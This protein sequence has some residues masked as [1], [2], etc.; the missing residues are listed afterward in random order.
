ANAPRAKTSA[1]AQKKRRAR[2]SSVFMT[3]SDC[4]AGKRLS[5]TIFVAPRR[6]QA[7]GLLRIFDLALDLPA[8]SGAA[9]PPTDCL[10]SPPPPR[11]FGQRLRPLAVSL[12]SVRR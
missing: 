6:S 8:P 12:R 4:G 10:Y 5:S 3:G 9:R 7:F 11:P 1:A 2:G